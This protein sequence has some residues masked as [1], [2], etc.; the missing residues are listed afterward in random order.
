M[1]LIY[2][3]RLLSGL[4]EKGIILEFAS[5]WIRC[6]AFALRGIFL[7]WVESVAP[8]GDDLCLKR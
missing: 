7:H 2:S 3:V 1:K 4:Y 5:A 8:M 6:S